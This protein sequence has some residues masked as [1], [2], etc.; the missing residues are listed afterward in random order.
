[1]PVGSSAPLA[2][3]S[4]P[5]ATAVASASGPLVAFGPVPTLKPGLPPPHSFAAANVYHAKAL[6]EIAAGDKTSA[7][8]NFQAEV[9]ALNNGLKSSIYKNS[10]YGP[11]LMY[12]IAHVESG[13]LNDPNSAMTQY[14]TL[15][16]TY[17]VVSYPDRKAVVIE[18]QAIS[19]A[20]DLHNQK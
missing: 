8:A 6:A 10:P 13:F 18:R 17:Q 7:T 4:T 16:S 11:L 3:P 12:R 14:N 1:M 2:S 20:A 9:N 5:V 19:H 15:L